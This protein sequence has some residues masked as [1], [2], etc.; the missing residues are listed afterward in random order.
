[1]C[2]SGDS[3]SPKTGVQARL[4]SEIFMAS[5]AKPGFAVQSASTPAELVDAKRSLV[6]GMLVSPGCNVLL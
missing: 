5:L 6:A 4:F 3:S 2:R 1:M